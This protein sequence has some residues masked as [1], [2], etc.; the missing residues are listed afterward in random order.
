[1]IQISI[2]K[3]NPKQIFYNFKKTFS[4]CLLH[5]STQWQSKFNISKC[6]I[7]TT[8]WPLSFLRGLLPRWQQNY[9]WKFCEGLGSYYR[10]LLEVSQS[11]QSYNNQG[12]SYFGAYQQNISI[13]RTWYDY[14]TSQITS[15]TNS[16]VWKSS[17]GT[18]LHHLPEIHWR[19]PETCF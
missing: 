2:G 13:Q 3:S 5:W 4:N 17:P 16:W 14:Q 9:N 18:L 19:S 11:Y 15:E 12:K 8:S 7:H 10:Q 1:M 6:H